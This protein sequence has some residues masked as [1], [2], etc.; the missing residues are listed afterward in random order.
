ALEFAAVMAEAGDAPMVVIEATYG[1]Y[2]VVDLLQDLGATVFLANPNALNWG[3]AARQERRDRRDRSGGHVAVGSPAAGVDRAA[4]DPGAA[5]A[6]AVS[7]QVGAATQRHQG[8]GV[9]GVGPRMGDA[10]VVGL[11]LALRESG[12]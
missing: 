3:G 4:G 10:E 12:A 6:G 2:W 9:R 5:R 1:W 8:L 7:R 11:V